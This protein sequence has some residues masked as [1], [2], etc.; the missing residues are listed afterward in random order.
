MS[1]LN[2]Q[3]KLKFKGMR[4]QLIAAPILSRVHNDSLNLMNLYQK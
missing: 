2:R 3:D 1:I 4:C